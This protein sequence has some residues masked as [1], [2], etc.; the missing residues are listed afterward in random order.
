MNV[1]RR[2]S[3]P[4][5]LPDYLCSPCPYHD[6]GGLTASYF[7]A[8]LL[9]SLTTHVAGSRTSILSDNR[10]IQNKVGSRTNAV[11]HILTAGITYFGSMQSASSMVGAEFPPFGIRVRVI[12]T[13]TVPHADQCN[14]PDG[15][16]RIYAPR[17]QLCASSQHQSETR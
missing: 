2:R 4:T 13:A 1:R 14:D 12:E 16:V 10:F 17:C 11:A 7:Q 9:P 5:R 8:S 3:S 15:E 6:K